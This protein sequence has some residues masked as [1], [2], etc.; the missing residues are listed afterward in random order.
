MRGG[1]FVEGDHQVDNRGRSPRALDRA[2][3]RSG[4]PFV[5]EM[6]KASRYRA[7][8]AVGVMMAGDSVEANK[9]VHRSR[10]VVGLLEGVGDLLP[11]RPV[12]GQLLELC[13]ARATTRC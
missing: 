10:R 5:K 9:V 3:E 6:A 7:G 11:V 4:V 2:S 13:A 1:I 8:R 12:K